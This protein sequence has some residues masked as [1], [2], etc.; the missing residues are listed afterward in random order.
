MRRL[1]AAAALAYGA[2][3]AHVSGPGYRPPPCG[4]GPQLALPVVPFA[5]VALVA[6]LVVRHLERRQGAR[7]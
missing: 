5:S 3:S 6:R 2:P 7:R 1:A 4:P